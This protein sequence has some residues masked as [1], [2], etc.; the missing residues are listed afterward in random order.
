MMF[1]QQ[2]EYKN[3]RFFKYIFRKLRLIDKKLSLV[4]LI[5]LILCFFGIFDLKPERCL[6]VLSIL[7][8]IFALLQPKTSKGKKPLVMTMRVKRILGVFYAI[9]LC[10]A[11]SLFLYTA[12]RCEL[13]IQKLVLI[14]LI[15]IQIIPFYI[16][17]ANIMLFPLEKA[18]RNKYFK[19]AKQKIKK[20]NP[21]IIGIT[22]SYGKTSVKHI[23]GHVLR[24][25]NEALFTP[26]SVNTIMGVSRIIRERLKKEH[27][28]FVVEMGAYKIGSIDYL[29]TLTP[30]QY[31]IITAIGDAHY[32]RFKSKETIAKAKFELAKNVFKNNKNGFVVINSEMVKTKF[33]DEHAKDNKKQIKLVSKKDNKKHETFVISKD[34]ETV[35][36][37][38]FEIKIDKKSYKVKAPIYG[39]HQIQNISIA[40]A[41][42]Y[43]LGMKPSS[44]VSA[45]KT[46]PQTTHRLEVKKQGSVTI[47]DNAYNS[48]FV[49]FTSALK[50]LNLLK[51]KNG[52]TILVTPGMVELGKLHD[53]QHFEIGKKVGESID[54]VLL[55]APDRIKTFIDGFS[56]T[57]KTNQKLI[58]FSSFQEA[59]EWLNLNMQSNDV[60]LFENDLPDLFES[61]VSI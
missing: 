26:G 19:E 43:S 42:A 16:I 29:C 52:R 48:N 30:P 56:K 38:E 45:L 31:G 41:M 7:F 49:G 40:F 17:L 44:I 24:S 59:R 60:V 9:F 27:K 1:F 57:S 2:E 37:L 55:V 39:D 8:A 13:H 12:V 20:L 35:N 50:T 51:K 47:I 11:T 4:L 32:E 15:L 33:I 22:G 23:L 28:Y 6:V 25:E 18:I 36:G 5:L 10:T 14:L 46:L 34:K 3:K 61:K 21:I 58:K 54:V 53:E